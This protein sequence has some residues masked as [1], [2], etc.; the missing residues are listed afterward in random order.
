MNA[1]NNEFV[2][3]KCDG[4]VLQFSDNVVVVY[5]DWRSRGSR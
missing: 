4:E 5:G 2:I 1:L 3:I